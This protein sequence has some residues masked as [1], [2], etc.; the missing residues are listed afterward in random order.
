MACIAERR[1]G[2]AEEKVETGFVVVVVVVVV[3]EVVV[4]GFVVE[5]MEV[6]V[7]EGVVNFVVK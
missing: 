3:K 4:S 5:E 2:L 1:I 7:V 6:P